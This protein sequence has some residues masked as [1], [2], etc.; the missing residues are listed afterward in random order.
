MKQRK[1]REDQVRDCDAIRRYEIATDIDGDNVVCNVMDNVLSL[2][3]P[4]DRDLASPKFQFVF[5]DRLDLIT[6]AE[7]INKALFIDHMRRAEKEKKSGGEI[8]DDR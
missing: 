6:F 8:E 4:A 7:K 5:R 1:P 2:H 3:E